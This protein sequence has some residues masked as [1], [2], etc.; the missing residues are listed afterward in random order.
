MKILLIV[1]GVVVVVVLAGLAI[2]DYLTDDEED[3]PL[4]RYYGAPW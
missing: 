2:W 4:D 1:V 3:D